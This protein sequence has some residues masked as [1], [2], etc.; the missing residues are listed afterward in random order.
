MMLKKTFLGVFIFI[1]LSGCGTKKRTVRKV[2]FDTKSA[3]VYNPNSGIEAT[4]VKKGIDARKL[5][6]L[7]KKDDLPKQEFSSPVEAKSESSGL[8]LL[9]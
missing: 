1:F 8:C 7:D 9:Q 3:R 2:T 4:K 6:Q 5:E